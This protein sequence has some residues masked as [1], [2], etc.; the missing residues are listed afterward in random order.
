MLRVRAA[1]RGATPP[2]PAGPSWQSVRDRTP[3]APAP[4]AAA[5]ALPSLRV[6]RP[7]N[8]IVPISEPV[9]L[10]TTSAAV[11]RDNRTRD[12]IRAATPPPKPKP[13]KPGAPPE[14]VPSA[15]PSL[16][17]I[18]QA[19]E[20]DDEGDGDGDGGGGGDG[21]IF[22]EHPS[23]ILHAPRDNIS[24]KGNSLTPTSY[25][26]NTGSR[27]LSLQHVFKSS[28]MKQRYSVTF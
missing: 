21:R 22:P 26:I 8:E 13:R 27:H 18:L 5:D 14:L 16:D 19:Q 9:D 23:P 1:A 7:V 28:L 24:R 4:A 25:N 15:A 12:A 17:A 2:P 6:Y 20:A 10:P 11:L 3:A